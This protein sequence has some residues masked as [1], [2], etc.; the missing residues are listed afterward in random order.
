MTLFNLFLSL[1]TLIAMILMFYVS[2][3]DEIRALIDWA[4]FAVHRVVVKATTVVINLDEE[5]PAVQST[6]L[7]GGFAFE[8]LFEE[9]ASP[10]EQAVEREDFSFLLRELEVILADDDCDNG[11]AGPTSPTMWEKVRPRIAQAASMALALFSSRS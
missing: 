9:E 7:Q 1:P 8:Y 5:P 4:V 6:L 3:E 11:E 10:I 2:W